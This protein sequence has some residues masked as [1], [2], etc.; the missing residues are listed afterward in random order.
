[1]KVL[2]I[3]LTYLLFLPWISTAQT[4]QRASP[5]F[6]GNAL[7]ASV[8]NEQEKASPEDSKDKPIK[9]IED[10]EKAKLAKMKKNIGKLFMAVRT[11]HPPE[12][13]DSP[14]NLGKKIGVREK[15]EFLILEV[16]QNRSGTMNFYKVRLESGKIGY[17]SAD[18]Y[19]LEIRIRDGSIMPVTKRVSTKK[20][21]PEAKRKQASKALEMVK[22]H[23]IPSDPVSKDKRTV[24]RRMLE[25]RATSFP[26][27]KWR[28]ESTEIG[29]NKYRVM[30]YAEGESAR[31]IHRTW[32]VD[33]S[34]NKVSPENVA[35]RELY[36]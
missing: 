21:S 9:A 7:F 10:Y 32:I 20:V 33:L 35:A 17:L 28:Y 3:L 16:V 29:N 24:E 34:T 23:L 5:K 1:M 27:L 19:N 6:S 11:A 18:G 22:N 4:E 25:L 26:K 8:K 36:R 15:E 30:Q 31:P 13:Y 14:E 2:P 12:F